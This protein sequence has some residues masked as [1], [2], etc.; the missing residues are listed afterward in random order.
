MKSSFI[1]CFCRLIHRYKYRYQNHFVLEV[2]STKPITQKRLNQWMQTQ[3][4]VRL[5]SNHRFFQV[6]AYR[7]DKGLDQAN[8][9]G[10]KH[11]Q[12]QTRL[13]HLLQTLKAINLWSI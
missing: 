8:S 7:R 1:N 4:M 6:L 3:K 2:L 10:D 12:K 9:I 11:V 5:T 13:Q